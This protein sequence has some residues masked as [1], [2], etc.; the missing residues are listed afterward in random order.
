MSTKS[1]RCAVIG[2][3]RMGR[4]HTRLYAQSEGVDCLVEKPLA[5]SVD[6]ARAI[7]DAAACARAAGARMV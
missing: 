1:L 7:A 2:A 3:G 4:H 5:P 6:E